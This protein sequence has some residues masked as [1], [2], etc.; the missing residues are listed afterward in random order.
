MNL[1][2]SASRGG[3][4]RRARNT[5]VLGLLTGRSVRRSLRLLDDRNVTDRLRG[6][7]R[8]AAARAGEGRTGGATTFGGE[9]AAA[10]A[11]AALIDVVVAD[12]LHAGDWLVR[13]GGRARRRGEDWGGDAGALGFRVA[14]AVHH[15]ALVDGVRADLR[16]SLADGWARRWGEDWF[17]DAGAFGVRV[18]PA[19][20]HAAFIDGVL[21]EGGTL[22]GGGINV[23]GQ[24][25]IGSG[26]WESRGKSEANSDNKDELKHRG[27]SE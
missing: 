18:A 12:G 7:L 19:V 10:K 27:M 9:G 24:M 15:A 17:G 1:H 22:R 20:P 26:S 23:V 6:R 14:S 16:A 21:A 11:L 3:G 25:G 13:T 4:G 2:I 5:L 8:Q